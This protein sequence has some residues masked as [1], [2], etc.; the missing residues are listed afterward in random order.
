MVGS[1][2]WFREL[3]YTGRFFGAEEALKQGY[4]SY[5]TETR[6]E[7]LAKAMELAKNIASKSPV[8][9]ATLKQNI[10]YSRDHTVE[11]GL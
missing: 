9:I 10:V 3:A 8:G 7:C 5:V 6:E 2:T 11:E 1:S 4:V